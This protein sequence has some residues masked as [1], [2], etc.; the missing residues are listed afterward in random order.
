MI[1]L[2]DEDE[3]PKSGSSGRLHTIA[4]TTIR[5][6]P[7]I[8]LIVCVIVSGYFTFMTTKP[9]PPADIAALAVSILK[10]GDA[11]PEM[12]AWAADALGIQTDI[13]MPAKSIRQ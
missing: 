10:S 1:D 11:P 4:L 6:V 5:F 13:P 8:I 9:K 7:P 2:V 12:Q 3:L